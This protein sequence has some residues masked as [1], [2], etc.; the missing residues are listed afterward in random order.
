MTLPPDIDPTE[1]AEL[2][3]A[4]NIINQ[5][6]DVYSDQILH[7]YWVEVRQRTNDRLDVFVTGLLSDWL[8]KRDAEKDSQIQRWKDYAEGILP[9]AEHNVEVA[10]E[11]CEELRARIADLEAALRINL[12]GVS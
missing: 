3:I 2:A 5:I 6:A 8:M 11:A 12:G 9:G 10:A 4:R 7:P 1:V